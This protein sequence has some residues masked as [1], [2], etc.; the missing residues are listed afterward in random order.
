[1]IDAEELNEKYGEFNWR[2]VRWHVSRRIEYPK[3]T[4]YVLKTY[5]PVISVGL[6]HNMISLPSAN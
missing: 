3:M 4:A 5:T 2:V 1:M 6:E